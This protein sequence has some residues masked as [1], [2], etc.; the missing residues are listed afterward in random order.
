MIKD[1]K[2]PLD[3]DSVTGVKSVDKGIFYIIV[4]TVMH[5]GL[6]IVV[7]L[8]FKTSTPIWMVI[9]LVIILIIL[10]LYIYRYVSNRMMIPP[11]SKLFL[12]LTYFAF[13]MFTAIILIK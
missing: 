12:S 9:T 10:P 13:F 1:Y 8:W 7:G 11:S 6:F 2:K 4:Q 3:D 5:A